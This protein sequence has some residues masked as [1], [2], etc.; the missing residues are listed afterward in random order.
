MHSRGVADPAGHEYP[1]GHW[2]HVESPVSD[3]YVPAEQFAHDD[4]AAT[5]W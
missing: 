2:P 4:C 3:W 5:D 1:Q